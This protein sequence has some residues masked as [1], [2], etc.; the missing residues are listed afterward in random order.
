[1]PNPAEPPGV[2]VQIVKTFP[3][4]IDAIRAKFPLVSD[5]R[6]LLFTYGT[7]LHNPDGVDV[8][9]HLIEHESVHVRQ[10]REVGGPEKWWELYLTDQTFR[11]RQEMEGCI[12]EYLTFCAGPPPRNRRAR[13]AHLDTIA[14]RLSSGIYGYMIRRQ[15]AKSAILHGVETTEV[16]I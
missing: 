13:F 12:V 6:G 8:P 9:N 10:Q 1:M 14:E 7:S 15:A 3:P 5:R 11:L 16:S 2:R 4:N